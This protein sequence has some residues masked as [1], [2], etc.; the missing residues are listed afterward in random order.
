MT[1][2]SPFED[3][4]RKILSP[5]PDGDIVTW[6]EKNIKTIPYSPMPGPFRIS[7]TPY[8]AEIFRA[9][10]DPEIESVAVMG[11]VQSGK[12]LIPELFSAY[13]PC[14]SPGP[15]IIFQDTNNNAQ[16]F[17]QTR[18]RPLWEANPV[19]REMLGAEMR[20]KWHTTQFQ[21]NIC[22]VLGANAERNLQRRSCRFVLIDEAWQLPRGHIGEAIARTTAFKWQA[23]VLVVSQGGTEDDD[24][25]QL[26]NSGDRREWTFA[27]PSCGTRQPYLWEKII[28]PDEAKT[29]TGWNLD[30]IRQKTVYECGSCKTHLK[31]SNSVRSEM[32][33]TGLWVPMN[34]N[35]PKGRRSYH[36]NALAMQWGLTWGDLAVE[37]IESKRALDDHADD[38]KRREFFQK[39]L[40]IPWSDTQ[41]VGGFEIKAGGYKLGE[42]W[43]DE[44]AFIQGRINEPPF[45]DEQKSSQ[46]F[47]RLRF[48]SVDVQRNGFYY[49]VRSWS[50]DGRSRLLRWGFV[51]EWEDLRRV[52]KETFVVDSGV[53]CDSGDQTED[54]Y[55]NCAA[56]GWRATKGDQ[57]NEFPWRVM[58]PMGLKTVLRPYSKPSV[59]VVGKQSCKRHNFSNLRLKDTLARLIRRGS[60][61][62]AD[63]AGEEYIKQMM[64]EIRTSTAS[65][66]PVWQ[67]VGDRANH[68]WD[69]EVIGLMPA[70][71]LKLVG[72]GKNKNA[73]KTE[74]DSSDQASENK[75][76][77]S[78][79]EPE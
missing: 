16:D 68:L 77:S 79:S 41:E 11:P 28:Y 78:Q 70:M 65:G 34:G 4:L 56:Y 35:S 13:I 20:D 18:L 51:P 2:C 24:F 33:R 39:R 73:T 40:A 25:T 23:K 75:T 8:L 49:I 59:E 57:R 43:A 15:T 58:T 64:S 74:S 31:D 36:Y 32:N 3:R 54:V 63:D 45:T 67:R 17:Q 71:G 52:Q 44:G 29:S 14:R 6:L 76:E 27:C 66:K 12:S 7:N 5:D 1:K 47:V 30:I 53:Y 50:T 55:R 9:L 62:R 10:T 21:R 42:E 60:H 72:L 37:C 69:C 26:H 46:D 38:S 61:T 22:W 19:T 48:M